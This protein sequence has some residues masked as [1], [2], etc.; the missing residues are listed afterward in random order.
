MA[1]IILIVGDSGSGK[2]FVL[3][4]ASHYENIQVI[5]RFISRSPRVGEENSVSSVFSVSVEEIQSLD[6]FYEGVQSNQWYGI[7]KSDLVNA[8]ACGKSPMVVCPNY[9]NLLQMSMDFPNLVECYF[10]YR[11]SSD[12]ELTLWKESLLA[13]GSSE[14]EIVRRENKRDQYFRELYI[15]HY[16]DYGS[17]VILNIYGLTTPEDIRLQ[18]E[19]LALKN[20]IDMGTYITNGRK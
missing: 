12:E 14:E 6:Y 18:L 20:G 15:Q 13:R 10:I 4:I 7:R 2:D 1:K 17:N 11:G 5:K 16:D 8:L 19:G 9:E 3:D